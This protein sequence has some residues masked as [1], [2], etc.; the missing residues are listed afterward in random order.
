MLENSEQKRATKLKKI[1]KSQLEAQPL[2][3]Y[4]RTVSIHHLE[5]SSPILQHSTSIFSLVTPTNRTVMHP[6]TTPEN[7]FEL[8][9]PHSPP[10]PI[11]QN[12]SPW[13]APASPRHH[14][15]KRSKTVGHS[16]TIIEEEDDNEE[17][18]KQQLASSLSDPGQKKLV[19]EKTFLSRTK[20]AAR[21]HSCSS[22][23]SI[24][25]RPRQ[26][27]IIHFM[28]LRK[29]RDWHR[30]SK[31][32]CEVSPISVKGSKSTPNKLLKAYSVSR[33][34]V[35]DDTS[36]ET[37]RKKKM[38]EELEDLITGRRTSTLKLSL[39]PKGLC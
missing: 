17:M 39:T 4:K 22:A 24:Q 20:P 2:P 1:F 34:C 18:H 8:Y 21:R 35:T 13:S 27:E 30:H 23:I 11:P 37:E 25:E 7:P 10:P 16:A 32:G 29:L 36:E 19:D 9:Q 6:I 26:F 12:S 28:T 14:N 31:V 5:I 15:T 33:M 38:Q 3:L